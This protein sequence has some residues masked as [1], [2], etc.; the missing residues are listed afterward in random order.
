MSSYNNLRITT[1]LIPEVDSDD[2]KTGNWITLEVMSV[3]VLNTT[4]QVYDGGNYSAEKINFMCFRKDE[5]QLQKLY[6]IDPDEY[7]EIIIKKYE[8]ESEKFRSGST[9]NQGR[10]THRTGG[11][12]HPY[13]SKDNVK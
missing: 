6:I 12:N 13:N 3:M 1:I 7:D 2:K 8:H 9:P 10:K 4:V 11:N 5:G